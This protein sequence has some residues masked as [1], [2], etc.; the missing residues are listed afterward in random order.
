MTQASTSR[1]NPTRQTRFSRLV[2]TVTAVMVVQLVLAAPAHADH[3]VSITHAPPPAA[4]AG[5]E[6]RL[7]VAVDGCWIFCTPI[8]LRTTYWTG[9]APKRTIKTNLGSFAPQTAVIVIPRRH[10]AKPA[11]SYFLKA[12][13]DYCPLFDICH[14]ARARLPESG[15]YSVPVV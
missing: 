14:G 9:D 1:R 3:T 11:V 10:V 2:L 5:S 4:I 8:S 6:A 15:A 13:Q 7:V 12:S